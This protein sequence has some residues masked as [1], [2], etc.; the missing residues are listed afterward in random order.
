V[1]KGKPKIEIFFEL[2]NRT[3]KKLQNW[4]TKYNS[5]AGRVVLVQANIES[6]LAYTMQCFQ[7]P[8]QT[9]RHIDKISRDFFWKKNN[10]NKGPPMVSW[11]KVCRP[12][13][14]GDLD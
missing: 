12:E 4:K 1:F 9:N 5:K 3:V 2:V 14:A 13:K 10:E 6:M 8:K 7:F 11:E